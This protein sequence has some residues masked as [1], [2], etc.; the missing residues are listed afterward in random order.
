MGT[1]LRVLASTVPGLLFH[2]LSCA[3]QLL[4]SDGQRDMGGAHPEV[5][6]VIICR[7]SVPYLRERPRSAV[8]LATV[9]CSLF[10]EDAMPSPS[11]VPLITHSTSFPPLKLFPGEGRG[12]K[13]WKL[14]R[15]S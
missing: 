1:K 10:G 13:T 7:G 6:S 15:Q 14:S 9:A 4:L 3:H 11:I 5:A 8:W 12:K 2:I